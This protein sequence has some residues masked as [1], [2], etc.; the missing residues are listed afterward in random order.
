MNI[1]VEKTKLINNNEGRISGQYNEKEKI[2][3]KIESRR[4]TMG[5]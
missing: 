1:N 2:T 3:M 5:I 4:K